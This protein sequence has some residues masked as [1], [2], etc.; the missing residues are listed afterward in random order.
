[1]TNKVSISVGR[2]PKQPGVLSMRNITI[3]ERFL[4]LLF[5]KP[6]RLMI[7][8]PGQDVKQIQIEEVKANEYEKQ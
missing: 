1:M 8:A 4:R 6:H 5:G 3:R 7:I 2:N